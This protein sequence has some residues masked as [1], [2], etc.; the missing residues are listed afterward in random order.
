MKK[1]INWFKKAIKRWKYKKAIKRCVKKAPLLIAVGNFYM[2]EMFA[3]YFDNKERKYRQIITQTGLRFCHEIMDKCIV[4]TNKAHK[5]FCE[6][7]NYFLY[8]LII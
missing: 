6:F 1:F 2:S 4:L 8:S 3:F 5:T 7:S